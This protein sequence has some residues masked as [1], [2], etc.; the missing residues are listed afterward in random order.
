M[1]CCIA[2]STAIDYTNVNSLPGRD[3]GDAQG[4][5]SIVHAGPSYIATS[6]LELTADEVEER[7]ALRTDVEAFLTGTG[8]LLTSFRQLA[9]ALRQHQFRSAFI[10]YSH[11]D[12]DF[13]L[14][15]H[16]RL[17]GHG[18]RCWLDEKNMVAGEVI[19]DAINAAIGTHDRVLLC[20]SKSS[21]ESWWVKDEIR[22][23]HDVERSKRDTRLIPVILDGYLLHTWSD[24]LAS[25]VRSRL[26]IDF[27]GWSPNSNREPQLEMLLKALRKDL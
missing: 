27:S 22:K 17:E 20:C 18:V 23:V 13:A 21:L 19:L 2:P 26:G 11:A 1:T 6:T 3:I 7:G 16:S 9:E 5:G 25:D 12:K 15:L 4:L 10:S 8:V 24:G 14:W